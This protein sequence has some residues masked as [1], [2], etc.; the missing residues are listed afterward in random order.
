[1]IEHGNEDTTLNWN[2]Q[3]DLDPAP[4]ILCRNDPIGSSGVDIYAILLAFGVTIW[5]T[6]L[7]G[8]V[9]SSRLRFLSAF[10]PQN[11]SQPC[12]L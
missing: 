4:A 1:M 11:E 10:L 9:F 5:K 8:G 12:N 2:A 3:I 7:N 6:R